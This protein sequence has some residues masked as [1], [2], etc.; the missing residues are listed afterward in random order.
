[1]SRLPLPPLTCYLVRAAATACY[2]LLATGYAA[3]YFLLNFFLATCYLPRATCYYPCT[4][5]GAAVAAGLAVDNDA[6]RRLPRGSELLGPVQEEPRGVDE[7]VGVVL[8]QPEFGGGHPWA[9]GPSQAL[10][11]PP[12]PAIWRWGQASKRMIDP[13]LGWGSGG[14]RSP[15]TGPRTGSPR[16]GGGR[17]AASS[18]P[19]GR[20][21]AARSRR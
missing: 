18:S 2:L 8:E 6:E 13:I 7:P 11:R 19:P 21:N 4:K 16:S 5:A 3:R 20:R 12:R 1:M 14:R 9:L 17:G 15:T 10:P